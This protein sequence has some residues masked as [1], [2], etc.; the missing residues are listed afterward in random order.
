[1]GCR[2]LYTFWLYGRRDI[3]ESVSVQCRECGVSIGYRPG[4]LALARVAPILQIQR[5]SARIMHARMGHLPLEPSG[6]CLCYFPLASSLADMVSGLPLVPRVSDAAKGTWGVYKYADQP[7]FSSGW[8][9]VDHYNLFP[10]R[11]VPEIQVSSGGEGWASSASD[12]W[13]LEFQVWLPRFVKSQ[14][15]QISIA[16]VPPTITPPRCT[17]AAL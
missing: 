1:M 12:S 3:R 17:R 15:M 13:M 8:L 9:L 10:N 11:T 14:V 2:W 6:D 7:T 5:D 16:I 4:N